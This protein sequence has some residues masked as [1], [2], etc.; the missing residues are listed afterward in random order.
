MW[1][2]EILFTVLRVYLRIT[3]VRGGIKQWTIPLELSLNPKMQI[4]HSKFDLDSNFI[5][6]QLSCI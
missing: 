1:E 6:V 2:N 5:F 4:A 3:H